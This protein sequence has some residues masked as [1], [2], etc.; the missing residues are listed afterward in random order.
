MDEICR[1]MK[2]MKLIKTS[3]LRKFTYKSLC[4]HF[5]TTILPGNSILECVIGK[6]ILT[7]TES[8]IRAFKTAISH[9]NLD[10]L[11]NIM[12]NAFPKAIYKNITLNEYI[13]DGN[14]V[15]NAKS[16]TCMTKTY[17]TYIDY[18]NTF[19]LFDCR[20]CTMSI[21][22][23]PKPRKARYCQTIRRFKII[24]PGRVVI[25]FDLLDKYCTMRLFTSSVQHL[26]FLLQIVSYLI[27]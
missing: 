12:L 19:G 18:K 22:T 5:N 23:T 7:K 3:N 2:N 15:S 6:I 4:H 20:L 8:P 26:D 11:K 13:Y 21:K 14:S 9:T 24:I 1:E 17:H 25:Q 10:K 16:N 27:T